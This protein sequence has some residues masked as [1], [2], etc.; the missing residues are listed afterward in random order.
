M[1]LVFIALVVATLLAYIPATQCGYIW[2]DDDYVTENETLK[3]AD[4]LRRIWFEIGATHQYYPLVHTTYWIEYQMWGLSPMGYHVTNILLHAIAAFLLGVLLERL[5]VPG[6]WLAAAMFAVHPVHVESVAWITERKNTL[7]AVFYLSS[8]I[9]FFRFAKSDDSP[10]DPKQWRWYALSLV[11]FCC[12]LFSKTVTVTLPAAILLVRWWQNGAVTRRDVALVAPM[13]VIAVPLG[14]ITVWVE[15]HLIGTS[16]IDLGLSPLDRLLVAGRAVWFYAL[17]LVWPYKLTFI[18]PRWQVSAFVWWQY[19]FPLAFFATCFVLWSQ[20]QR[21]GHGP[22]AAVLFFAGTLTPALGFVDVYPMRF[23][24]VAD[25]FQYLASIGIIVLM[26][27]ILV[28]AADKLKGSNQRSV[29]LIASPVLMCFGLLTWFQCYVYKDVET[30]WR[31]TAGKNPGAM[32]AHVN[33]GLELHEQGR[34]QAAIES[35]TKAIEAE[36]SAETYFCRAMA[37]KFDEDYERAFGDFATVIRMAPNHDEA[38]VQRGM[39]FE[40]HGDLESA[41][42]DYGNAVKLNNMNH[43]AL[44][45]WTRV[46]KELEQD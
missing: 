10:K 1:A 33:L 36:P 44:H 9:A 13:L 11:L 29:F 37:Y 14:L 12:A 19:L 4:G 35:F 8:A 42:A 5:K 18:Y 26:A 31:D 38:Y 30:L 46:L 39:L 27:G 32:I 7:S 15:T 34:I 3:T 41:L 45:F 21:F 20:R 28:A 17:K 6:G 23:S 24:F 16:K 43:R 40:L 2:D 22:L 25:H